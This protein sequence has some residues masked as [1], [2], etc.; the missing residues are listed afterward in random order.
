MLNSPRECRRKENP[1]DLAHFLKFHCA[2][3][4]K[5]VPNATPRHATPDPQEA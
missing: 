2:A 3:H 4:Q 5:N 1:E